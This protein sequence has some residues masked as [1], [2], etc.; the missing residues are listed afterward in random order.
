[1]TINEA[2]ITFL[3][4]VNR[5][6]TNDNISVDKPRFILLF[7]R[8]SKA[9][10]EWILEKSN[11]DDLRDIQKLLVLD[12]PLIKN[13][14]KENHS[15]FKLPEDYLNLSNIQVYSSKES[16]KNKK[17][18]VFEVK[19][20][21]VEELISDEFNKP[22]FAFRESFYTI[23]S[24]NASIYKTD[25]SIDKVLL[26][27]YRYP[28]EVDIEGYI[29]LEGKSS[30]NIDPELDDKIVNKILL[31]CSKDYNLNNSDFSK[32]QFEKD[33]LFNEI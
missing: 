2:Y 12:M 30:T 32:Y 18:Q 21:D 14:D 10:V 17:I 28:L 6:L 33:R 15:D 19:N 20:Q 1:M 31:A 22:S 11:E 5:N 25:F 13:S 7:N 27:Y 24:D 8:I 16:C 4:L 23:A 3:Q 29:N 26:S 9:Y